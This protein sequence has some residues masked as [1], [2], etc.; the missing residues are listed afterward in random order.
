[1]SS[2]QNVAVLGASGTLGAIVVPALLQAGFTVTVISRPGGR[3]LPSNDP[4]ISLKYAAYDDVPAL[5]TALHNQDALIELFNPT[6]TIHRRT[7]IRAALASPTIK[8]IITN[9]FGFDTFHPA[10]ASIPSAQLK[11]AAQR[12]LEEELQAAAAG[13]N[14]SVP[15]WT[16]IVTGIWFDWA[17]RAGK[18]WVDGVARTITRFGSGDQHTSISRA[19]LNGEAVVAVL[20][21]PHRFRNR[22]AYFASHTVTTNELIALLVDDEGGSETAT[23][24]TVVDVPDMAAFSRE[25]RRLWDEDGRNGVVDRLHTRAWEM[26]AVAAVFDEEGGFG[27]DLRGKVEPGWG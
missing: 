2:I 24:W 7:I 18:F 17:M 1:M 10:V 15:A 14:T 8:H 9:E 11:V 26:L 19:A 16:G 5:T 25:A 23:P 20:R 4:S 27:A 22:A 6:A 21:A 12:V 3:A 13:G